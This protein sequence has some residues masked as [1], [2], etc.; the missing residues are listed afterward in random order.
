M[1]KKY[2]LYTIQ[3]ILEKIPTDKL[4]IC[5][6]ELTEMLLQAKISFDVLK[7]FDSSPICKLPNPIIWE[8]DGKG[9]IQVNHFINDIKALVTKQKIT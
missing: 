3:D 9:N 5:M 2:E 6:K 1:S 7:T 4:K 8:D